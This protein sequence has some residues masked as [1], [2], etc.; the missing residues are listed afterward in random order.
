MTRGQRRIHVFVW[1]LI[2][3][4]VPALLVA[5]LVARAHSP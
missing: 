1:L 5:A 4:V 3:A 2:A